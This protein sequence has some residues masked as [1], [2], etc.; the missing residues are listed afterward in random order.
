MENDKNELEKES[1]KLAEISVKPEDVKSE[2]S[3]RRCAG[4]NY[5]AGKTILVIV[6]ILI[7]LGLIAAVIKLSFRGRSGNSRNFNG[8]R[9]EM[10]NRRGFAGRGNYQ[11]MG[12]GISGKISNIDGN[13]ITISYNNQ[14]L[15]VV[16]ADNTAIYKSNN[17]ASKTDIKVGDTIRVRGA[18]NSSGQINAS[19]IIDQS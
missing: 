8:A 13:N 3:N 18:A 14:N 2:N 7:S 16:I 1:T 17:I 9:I 19:A 10:M 5:S 11:T 6:L 15:V 4:N 12:R